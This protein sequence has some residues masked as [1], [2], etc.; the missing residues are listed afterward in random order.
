M[1]CSEGWAKFDRIENR[2]SMSF[3]DIT[4]FETLNKIKIVIHLWDK[5]LQGVWNN[6]AESKYVLV[7]N[8]LLVYNEANAYWHYCGIPKLERLFSHTKSHEVSTHICNLC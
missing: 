4:K 8:I 6:K 7:V 3:K 5:E 1:T 2:E